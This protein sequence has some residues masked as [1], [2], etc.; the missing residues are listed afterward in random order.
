MPMFR[1]ASRELSARFSDLKERKSH[2]RDGHCHNCTQSQKSLLH[3]IEEAIEKSSKLTL[4]IHK[5][6]EIKKW[7][8]STVLKILYLLFFSTKIHFSSVKR[9]IF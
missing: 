8:L 1:I 6:R 4:Y 3:L 9:V 2:M 5:E 7:K